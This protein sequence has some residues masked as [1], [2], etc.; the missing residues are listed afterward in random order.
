MST[1]E[2]LPVPRRPL[3]RRARAKPLPPPAR[4]IFAGAAV[5][6]GVVGLVCVLELLGFG[7]GPVDLVLLLG[8]LSPVVVVPGCLFA[9]CFSSSRRAGLLTLLGFASTILCFPFLYPIR[10][11]FRSIAFDLLAR[12]S[13]PIVAAIRDFEQRHSTSPPNLGALVPEFLPEVPGTGMW[14]Y[15]DYVYWSGRDPG[16]DESEP[17]WVLK[18]ECP[19]GILSWDEYMYV[20]KWSHS[21]AGFDP[22]R[23][24][25][26]WY[27]SSP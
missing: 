21:G 2:F 18:V 27:Y 7:G 24:H 1:L 19:V 25:F 11:A 3:E 17:Y 8:F 16:K 4:A 9:I 26:D 14:S 12:R 6:L 10:F 23:S 22:E 15:P 20:S 13:R 5:A